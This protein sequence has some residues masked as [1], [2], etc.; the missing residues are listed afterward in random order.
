MGRAGNARA[1][2]FHAIISLIERGAVDTT[3]W[4]THRAPFDAVPDEFRSG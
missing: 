1:R 4:I 2:I 3:P